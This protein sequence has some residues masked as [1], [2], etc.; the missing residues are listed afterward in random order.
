MIVALKKRKRVFDLN[1]PRFFITRRKTL[2]CFYKGQAHYQD[3]TNNHGWHYNYT[4]GSKAT[5]TILE[6]LR[7]K[8]I[9]EID[10]A[11]HI[12]ECEEC[13]KQCSN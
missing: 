1:Y 12:Q 9:R 6:W 7:R 3:L 2:W 4:N 11:L 5:K 13:L 10:P 8:A